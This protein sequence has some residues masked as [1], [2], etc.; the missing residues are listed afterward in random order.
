M[1]PP[2]L[3]MTTMRTGVETSRRAAREPRSWRKPSSPVTIVVGRPLA[4]AAPIP[5]ET[6]PSIPFAPRL[7]RNETSVSPGARNCSWSRIAI[8]DAV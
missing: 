6:S 2:L 5:D 1:P 4:C 7:Q 8:D 3:S